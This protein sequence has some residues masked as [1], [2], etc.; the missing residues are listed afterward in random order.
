MTSV[1]A[2][3]PG[4]ATGAAEG[5]FDESTPLQL[6]DTMVIPYNEWAEAWLILSENRP[7]HLVVEEF[8]LADNDFKADLTGVKIEGTLELAFEEI[9]YRDRS[10]KSQVSDDLL[11]EIGW[12]Q[13]GKDVGWTDG[14]DANDAIIHMLGYVAFELQH[15][16]TLKEYFR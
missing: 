3:D 9:H 2:L 8:N 16:P 5:E 10:T 7:D 13:T 4:Y 12:W 14:R 15:L 6:L 1:I 11:K